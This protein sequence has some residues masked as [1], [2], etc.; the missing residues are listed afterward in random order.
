M[1]A[2]SRED[3]IVD[4]VVELLE[5]TTHWSLMAWTLKEQIYGQKKIMR[6]WR[7]L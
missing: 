7:K 2:Y 3:Q 4:V 6:N 1:K 5:G